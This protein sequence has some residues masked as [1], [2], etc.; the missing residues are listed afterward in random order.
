MTLTNAS[1]SIGKEVH[2]SMGGADLLLLVVKR[3]IDESRSIA[4][5]HG[6]DEME[7]PRHAEGSYKDKMSGHSKWSRATG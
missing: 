4:C 7:S 1:R 5:S 2:L 3:F 6:I